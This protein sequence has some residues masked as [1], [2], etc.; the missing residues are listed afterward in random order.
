[1]TV[2]NNDIRGIFMNLDHT[3][4]N[5]GKKKEKRKAA[6]SQGAGGRQLFHGASK[7]RLGRMGPSG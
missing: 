2:G 1:M 6:V 7:K 3:W 5:M 4:N